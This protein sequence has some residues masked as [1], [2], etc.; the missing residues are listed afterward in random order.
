MALLLSTLC[1]YGQE[2][3]DDCIIW[4]DGKST[5]FDLDCSISD[6]MLFNHISFLGGKDEDS[7]RLINHHLDDERGVMISR[8]TQISFGLPTNGTLVIRKKNGFVA[9]LK[10]DRDQVTNLNLGAVSLDIDSILSNLK[11]SLKIVSFAWDPYELTDGTLLNPHQDTLVIL[12]IIENGDTLWLDEEEHSQYVLVNDTVRLFLKGSR[13]IEIDTLLTSKGG[14][15]RI[16]FSLRLVTRF[17]HSDYLMTYDATSNEI[18]SLKRNARSASVGSGLTLYN[19]VRNFE[20]QWLGPWGT[21]PNWGYRLFDDTRGDGIHTRLRGATKLKEYIDHNNLWYEWQGNWEPAVGSSIRRVIT[22]HWSAQKS[23]DFFNDVYGRFGWDDNGKKVDIHAF[24]P[25]L[26]S[27]LDYNP[28]CTSEYLPQGIIQIWE[29]DAPNCEIAITL[30]VIGH[31]YTHGVCQY[32]LG[33]TGFFPE[34]ESGALEE[35]FCDIFGSMVEYY[36]YQTPSNWSINDENWSPLFERHMDNPHSS[37]QLL[38]TTSGATAW[39]GQPAWYDEPDYWQDVNGCT[40]NFI[41]DFCGIHVNS[42]VQNYWFYLLSEGGNSPQPGNNTIVQGIGREKA[43]LITYRNLTEHMMS[44]SNYADA[45]IGSILAA[46]DAFGACSFEVEQTINAWDAVNV[47][48]DGNGLHYDLNYDC[49]NLSDTY[50]YA[51][52]DLNVGCNYSNEPSYKALTAGRILTI[53]PG[54][55]S[56]S[57]MHLKIEPCFIGSG[58]MEEVLSYEGAGSVDNVVIS[59]APEKSDA[60]RMVVFPNPNNGNFAI[61]AEQPIGGV[62]YDMLGRRITVMQKIDEHTLY[63]SDL[64]L[65]TYVVRVQMEDGSVE[66]AKVVVN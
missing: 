3:I 42:G 47:M 61:R 28:E 39:Q 15:S 54:F 35:S 46:V 40:A 17:H 37:Y 18:I 29:P 66:N 59:E 64:S 2:S 8:Y 27:G 24:R 51:L 11:D 41:N 52:R 5:L 53:E 63:V 10:Y 56:N 50:I 1:S 45:R 48:G 20:T 30:D 38:H 23:W 57:N 49:A 26:Y 12:E 31:E 58:K 13:G 6:S 43:A 22:A 62:V 25:W 9:S 34:G 60:S 7:F 4:S 14:S 36:T 21:I 19:D 33:G 65:G 16:Q 32:A 44:Y 55:E